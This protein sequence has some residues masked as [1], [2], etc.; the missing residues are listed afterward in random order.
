M[1]YK[2][3]QNFL[4][5]EDTALRE[6][7]YADIKS[8]DIVLEIG[9]GKGILTNILA[10]KAKKIYAIEIDKKLVNYLKKTLP[11]NV[12]IIHGNAVKFDFN[13]IHFNKVVSN[14]PFQ[15]SSPI[16]FKLL[17]CDFDDAILIYQKDFA[18]RM[19]ALP[20]DNDYSHLTVHL[21]Y[22]AY[23]EVLEIVPKNSFK[24]KPKV[25]ACIVRLIPLKKPPFKVKD[26]QFFLKLCRLLFNNKRKM[27]GTIIKNNFDLDISKIPF[28]KERVENLSP[29]Q[30]GLLS[31]KLI[32]RQSFLN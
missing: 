31:D 14:L 12:E 13:K 1:K 10:D 17:D 11:K 7:R 18:K 25:D 2:L 9:P 16:T 19:V 30:I 27:I 20:G 15:I 28:K 5:D 24:P 8:S 23:C 6:V 3:G 21:Y 4:I 32:K 26:E 22:K 29:E